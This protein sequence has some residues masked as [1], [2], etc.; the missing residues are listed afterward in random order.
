MS[1]EQPL[2]PAELIGRVHVRMKLVWC[3]PSSACFGVLPLN[4]G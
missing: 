2:L 3:V 4:L 1:A